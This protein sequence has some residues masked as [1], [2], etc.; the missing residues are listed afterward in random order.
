[1]LGKIIYVNGVINS[2]KST[3]AR[4]LSE[5]IPSGVYLDGDDLIE[6]NEKPF[7]QRVSKVVEVA[8]EQACALA[9]LGKNV[10]V[11]YPLRDEDWKVISQI[12]GQ[13]GVEV[14]VVTLAPSK[15]TTISNRGDRNLS[16]SE[17]KRISQMFIEGYQ[18]RSFSHLIVEN[19]SKAPAHTVEE[20]RHF[21]GFETSTF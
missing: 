17:L 13:K 16:E 21:F 8:T 2:G 14:K 4:M 11:A 5:A 9:I 19:D 20:I 7:E 15:R 18:A 3:I 10:C 1:M 12:C 6:R